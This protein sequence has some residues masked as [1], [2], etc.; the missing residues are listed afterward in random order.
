MLDKYNTDIKFCCDV[1]V[2]LQMIEAKLSETDLETF[3]SLSPP[4]N[5]PPFPKELIDKMDEEHGDNL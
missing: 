4:M 1:D 5:P 3:L 2:L